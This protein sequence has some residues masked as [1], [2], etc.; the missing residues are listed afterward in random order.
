M[1]FLW[2][3]PLTVDH[4]F[5]LTSRNELSRALRALGV[6]ISA[7][8][9]YREKKIPMDG[10]SEVKYIHTG[11]GLF[12]KIKA[13]LRFHRI[14]F[15][16]LSDVILVGCGW[17][18]LIPM[19]SLKNIVFRKKQKLIMDLRSVPVDL[20]PGF[21]GLLQTIRYKLA[22]R[23]AAMFCDA[24]TVIT[25]D[26]KNSLVESYPSL[27]GRV[28]VWSSGVNFEHFKPDKKS[29][30]R[31]K[32]VLQHSFVIMHHGFLS[33]NRGLQN[34]IKALSL[35]TSKCPSVRLLLVG[36]GPARNELETLAKQLQL[37]K[38]IIITGKIPYSQIPAYIRAC[39][40]GI[41]PLPNIDC[42]NVSS[43]LKLM[44]Y[45]AMQKTV[46]V[47]DIPAHRHVIE[48]TGGGIF[49]E[50]ES[51]EVIAETLIQ[52]LKKKN[53]DICQLKK[54]RANLKEIISW[55]AQASSLLSFIKTL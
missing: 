33:L 26:L 1:N 32:L 12:G 6:N 45:L 28:G 43:P 14:M 3:M 18:H 9:F 10:F 40:V 11:K 29:F 44:E 25:H 15:V 51:P 50:N 41:I 38:Q 5:Q 53:H 22:I 19:A 2:I 8:V 21:K 47:T 34:I 27:K 52:L 7:V 24:I 35:I 23:M 13:S 46:I 42:W 16:D 30:V 17:P 54:N 49:I 31:D 36:D 39:D 4:A 20:E 55:Q 37:T 48:K